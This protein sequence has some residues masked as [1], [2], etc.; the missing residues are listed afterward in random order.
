[1]SASLQVDFHEAKIMSEIETTV[2]LA[3]SIVRCLSAIH[4][5][6]AMPVWPEKS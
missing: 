2:F 1:M 4:I 3:S 5:A 6:I